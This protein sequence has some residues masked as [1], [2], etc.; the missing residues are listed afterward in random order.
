MGGVG[1]PDGARA[2][3]HKSG[4]EEGHEY[5]RRP[6]R[7]VR[8]LY[9][10]VRARLLHHEQEYEGAPERHRD[11][12]WALLDQRGLGRQQESGLIRVPDEQR[13]DRD[14]QLAQR[15]DGHAGHGVF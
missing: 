14:C 2:V 9:E 7:E 6:L 10:D 1:D 4:R 13:V 12:G 15:S 5:H 3:E 8:L 11:H